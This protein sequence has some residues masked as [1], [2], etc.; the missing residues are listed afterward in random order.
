MTKFLPLIA[1]FLWGF[2]NGPVNFI[3]SHFILIIW[4]FLNLKYFNI[5]KLNGILVL[6]LVLVF[7]LGAFR[8]PFRAVSQMIGFFLYFWSGYVMWKQHQDNLL[9]YLRIVV[10]YVVIIG[11]VK[12]IFISTGY[13]ILLFAD[14]IHH[15]A[16]G[17]VR[18]DS[19]FN[20]PSHYVY[21]IAP[22]FFLFE[23]RGWR[24]SMFKSIMLLSLVL[25]F[26]T[27]LVFAFIATFLLL[28][29][30]RKTFPSAAVIFLLSIPFV[31]LSPDTSSRIYGIL[32]LFNGIRVDNHTNASSVALF[33][34][35]YAYY[36]FFIEEPIRAIVGVGIGAYSHIFMD[37]GIGLLRGTIY[38]EKLLNLHDANSLLLRGLGETGVAF[39]A[40][41]Y[42][43]Y[44]YIKRELIFDRR[45][46]YMITL[47]I[48]SKLFRDGN[49]FIGGLPFYLGL[50]YAR[51]KSLFLERR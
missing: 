36:S 51:N 15:N 31:L 45:I 7:L 23:F 14:K 50:L 19:I 17:I 6:F 20:E 28:N 1:L 13:P 34:H 44:R 24:Q 43:I 46:A 30:S 38:G 37:Y 40:G 35:A 12:W 25:T 41:L 2:E 16:M 48:L 9:K 32:D 47:L 10:V 27:I 33:S 5:P 26:S 49:L 42:I 4:I 22:T 11:W 3:L 8:S 29:L 39:L 18:F 21:C